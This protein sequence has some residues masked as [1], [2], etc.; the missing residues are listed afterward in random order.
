MEGVSLCEQL[1][2]LESLVVP[3]FFVWIG[4]QVKL[5]LLP[6]RKILAVGVALTVVAVLSM[7]VSGFA[8]PRA[9]NGWP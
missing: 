3:L 1:T 6:D 9:M 8:C 2:P 5:E 4:I 7:V